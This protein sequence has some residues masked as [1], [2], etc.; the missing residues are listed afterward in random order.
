MFGNTN[1]KL[2]EAFNEKQTVS[3]PVEAVVSRNLNSMHYAPV[4]V[5]ILA[6]HEQGKTF[7][8]I[9]LDEQGKARMRWHDEYSQYRNHFIG[10]L[11]MP[12][13]SC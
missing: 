4:D 13:Y 11:P 5:E 10:W 1:K 12:K 3:N 2:E 8:P 9:K 7:H 6:F